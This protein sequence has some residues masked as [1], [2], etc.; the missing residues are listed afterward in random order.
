MDEE[1]IE[2]NEEEEIEPEGFNWEHSDAK[3]LLVEDLKCGA[4]TQKRDDSFMTIQ[5][6]FDFRV[7]YQAT[8]RLKWARRLRDA[9]KQLTTSLNR[10]A[11]DSDAYFHDEG[12]Y[13]M[14]TT[15]SICGGPRW[16]GS[17]AGKLLRQDVGNGLHQ[18]MYDAEELY[19]S[20]PAYQSFE[21]GV[22]R[23]HVS[24]EIKRI[25]R[26]NDPNYKKKISLLF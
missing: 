26:L 10:A 16:D 11:A 14:T 4:I 13:P 20:R 5:E 2:E 6:A 1:E 3:R 25:K 17:E 19:M 23:K 18:S 9:R 12:I 22:F 24:H 21:I 8:D 7:E 15:K